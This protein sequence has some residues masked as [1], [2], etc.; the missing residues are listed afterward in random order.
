[1]SQADR[2]AEKWMQVHLRN[3][4][5]ELYRAKETGD[6]YFINQFGEVVTEKP[7]TEEV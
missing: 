3:Q 4:E 1:M 2:D 7:K 5:R 6:D